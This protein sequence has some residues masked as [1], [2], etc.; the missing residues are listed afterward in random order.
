[1][2]SRR[3]WSSGSQRMPARAAT[4]IVVLMRSVSSIRGLAACV[5][6][7]AVLTLA[8]PHSASA[9]GPARLFTLAGL[10]SVVAAAPQFGECT[11]GACDVPVR[12]PQSW[13]AGERRLNAGCVLHLADGT[14][15]LCH[16]NQLLALAL[17]GR[18]RRWARIPVAAIGRVI[19]ADI[20]PDG[21]VIALGE[22]GLARV[23]PDGSSEVVPVNGAAG[24]D[25]EP[26]AVAALPD[27]GA[28]VTAQFE[29]GRDVVRVAPDGRTTTL[30]ASLPHDARHREF[31][32]TAD[33]I[34]RLADGSFALAQSGQSRVLRLTLDGEISVLA[35]GG[36]GFADGA[37]A[38]A[39]DLGSV[40]AV[41]SAPDGRVL[42]AAEHGVLS[43]SADGRLHV[44]APSSCAGDF[45]LPGTPQSLST[46]GELAARTRLDGAVDLDALPD[47]TVA[48]L[49]SEPRS[50]GALASTRVVVV[51][52]LAGAARFTVAL[53]AK[54]RAT[55]RR[56]SPMS[57]PPAPPP[58]GS[59]YGAGADPAHHPRHAGGR[60]E[61]HPCPRRP[62][63]HGS[64]GA[65]RGD[66]RDRSDRHPHARVRSYGRAR[67]ARA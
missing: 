38:T 67:S 11:T 42:I 5:V 48:V 3:V 49:A 40:P 50:T 64:D 14:I 34:S 22:E 2:R 65:R 45:C 37:V 47:G 13:P 63:R 53:A 52:P 28:L 59:R 51:T 60:T 25:W 32:A 23:R 17:D 18:L 15:V 26:S 57:S 8:A 29:S 9:A 7:V 36:R 27:G 10:D 56:D 33:D 19:D 62:R 41:A 39:V 55:L 54:A 35:G 44:I 43:L 31:V 66:H 24:E 12:W 4:R 16:G 46:D 58:R 21:S 20:A 61:P 30:V 6:A 1:M